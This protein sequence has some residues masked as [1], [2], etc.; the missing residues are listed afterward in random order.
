MKTNEE[1]LKKSYITKGFLSKGDKC[2]D[3]TL[4]MYMVYLSNLPD[5]WNIKKLHKESLQKVREYFGVKSGF[6][7]MIYWGINYDCN[8]SKT[9]SNRHKSMNQ[10]FRL[11]RTLLENGVF[12]TDKKLRQCV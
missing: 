10:G 6:G 5:G 11:G 2:S 9:S 4:T 1:K 12:V 8:N 7:T 3:K